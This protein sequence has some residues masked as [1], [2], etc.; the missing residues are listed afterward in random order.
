[1]GSADASPAFRM[2]KPPL[3]LGVL[4]MLQHRDR[5][6]VH[7]RNEPCS[8]GVAETGLPAEQ[9]EIELCWTSRKECNTICFSFQGITSV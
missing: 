3:V 4:L 5:S 6:A 9:T 7:S 1:V 2:Q 8:N